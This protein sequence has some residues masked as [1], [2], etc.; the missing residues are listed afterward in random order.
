M[1]QHHPAH[2]GEWMQPMSVNVHQLLLGNKESF[3]VLNNPERCQK[4]FS[5]APK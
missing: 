4:S 3:C 5:F 2:I 1:A